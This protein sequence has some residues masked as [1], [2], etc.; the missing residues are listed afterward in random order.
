MRFSILPKNSFLAGLSSND[1][2]ILAICVGI[3]FF[4]WLLVKLSATYDAEKEVRLYYQL[5]VDRAFVESPPRSLVATIQGTGWNLL[6]EFLFGRHIRLDYQPGIDDESFKLSRSRLRSDVASQLSTDHIIVQD[7]N[8]DGL[9][10]GLE[11]RSQA[12]VPI[13][14]PRLLSFAAD[15]QAAG[16]L[17]VMPDSVLLDGPASQVSSYSF[18]L[19]DTLVLEELA[20]DFEGAVPLQ[21][22]PPTLRLNPHTVQLRL[23][24]EQFTEKSLFVPVTILNPPTDSIRVFPDRVKLTCVVGLHRYDSLSSTD[25]TLVADLASARLD[26]GKHTATIELTRQ[27]DY[28]HRVNLARRSIEFF[29]VQP[30]SAEAKDQ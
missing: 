13:R 9:Q 6:F 8:F 26:A 7:I 15:H 29:L 22:P 3:S 27:P 17:E 10:V 16:P 20:T 19:T 12:K 5:P 4:F 30:T 14:V 11:M 2:R 1:Q 28:V 25:F 18:W 24:V 23:P 21:A